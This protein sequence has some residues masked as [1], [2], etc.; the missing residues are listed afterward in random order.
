MICIG[1]T[2]SLTVFFS[3]ENIKVTGSNIYSAEEI[4]KHSG[5]TEGDNLFT[6][7]RKQAEDLLKGT[8][9]YVETVEFKRELPGTLTVKVT[10]AEEFACYNINGRF[11]TVSGSGWVLKETSEKPQNLV[12]IVVSDAE[13]EVGGEITFTDDR[14][15]DI[16][17]EILN[18]LSEVGLTANQIDVSDKIAIS[19]K[20]EGR[21]NV[22]LGTSNNIYEKIRHLNG[23]I[24]SIAPEK[25]GDINLS[26]WTSSNT[27]GTFIEKTE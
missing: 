26:M 10:D 18:S 1:I 7:S 14:P 13:C 15:P 25:S 22:Y 5:I 19:V 27:K 2:L 8:L 24:E 20:V 4:V 17:D 6:V 11:Y 21:F 9:P 23:M 16:I 3:I 12:D